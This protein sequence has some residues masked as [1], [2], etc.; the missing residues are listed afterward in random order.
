[1]GIQQVELT[2]SV[3]ADEWQKVI[4]KLYPKNDGSLL[5]QTE[6]LK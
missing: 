3:A 6:A 1:V 5:S 2:A 4:Y